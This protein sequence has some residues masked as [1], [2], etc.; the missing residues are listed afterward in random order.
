MLLKIKL[1]FTIIECYF[2]DIKRGVARATTQGV[3][4]LNAGVKSVILCRSFCVILS[5][6]N[7]Y[8]EL[9]HPVFVYESHF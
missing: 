6:T 8:T 5:L 7:I 2:K 9:T 4:D 3:G 1:G